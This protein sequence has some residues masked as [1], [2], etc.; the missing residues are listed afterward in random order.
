MENSERF[1]I[2]GCFYSTQNVS[3]SMAVFTLQYREFL[4]INVCFY[5]THRTFLHQWLFLLYCSSNNTDVLTSMALFTLKFLHKYLQYMS[6]LGTTLPGHLI[7]ICVTPAS[8]NS[9]T[10]ENK[11]RYSGM[12]PHSSLVLTTSRQK[13]NLWSIYYIKGQI[14]IKDRK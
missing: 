6:S 14:E 8:S 3:T 13:T 2:N 11:G 12:Y 7:L 1:Y 9:C 4:H 5:S 10:Q